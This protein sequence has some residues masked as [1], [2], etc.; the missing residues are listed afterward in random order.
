MQPDLRKPL[1]DAREQPLKPIDL[2]VW[3]DAALHQHTC[4]AHLQRLGD[5]LVDLFELEDVAFGGL[6]SL[7]RPIE[8]AE[9]A[10]LGAEVGVVDV[11]IDDVADHALGVKAAADSIGL[12]AQADEVR[13]VEVI[14]CLLAGQS[15]I[16]ILPIRRC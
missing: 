9:G 10:V 6:G 2:Q 4:S 15:H 1:L 3:V 14:E 5:L 7:Q 12:K 13:G 11:A 8:G 16:W